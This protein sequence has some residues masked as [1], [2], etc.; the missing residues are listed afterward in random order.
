MPEIVTAI[1]THAEREGVPVEDL[2]DDVLA[3]YWAD[4]WVLDRKNRPSLKNLRGSLTGILEARAEDPGDD[5]TDPPD[6]HP[7]TH[8][9]PQS[10]RNYRAWEEWGLAGCPPDPAWRPPLP[11]PHTEAPS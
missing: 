2:I 7:V 11:E 3:A 1:A 8:G 10:P 5:E 6:W 9:A 4:P